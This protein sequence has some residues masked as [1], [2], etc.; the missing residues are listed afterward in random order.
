MSHGGYKYVPS[1]VIQEL[2]SI[3]KEHGFIKDCDAM[4]KMV[5]YTKLGRELERIWHGMNLRLK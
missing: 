3:K 1:T 2:E 5:E 4:Q